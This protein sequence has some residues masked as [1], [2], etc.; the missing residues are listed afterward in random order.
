MTRG[1]RDR[2]RLAAAQQLLNVARALLGDRFLV[3]LADQVHVTFLFDI[4]EDADGL[5]EVRLPHPIGDART[6]AD[7]IVAEV[8][9]LAAK[10]NATKT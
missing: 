7:R 2:P 6:F 3:L 8:Q 10:R 9:G 4:A 1:S 5:W